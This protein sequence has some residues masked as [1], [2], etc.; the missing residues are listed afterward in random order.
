MNFPAGLLGDGWANGA[1]VLL[2]IILVWCLRTAPWRR[3]ADSGQWNVWLGSIVILTL[4]WSMNAGI[5]PGLNMHLLGVTAFTLMFDRQLAIV[6]L[7]VVLAVVTYNSG[8]LGHPLG[9]HSF[10]LNALLMV[11]FPAFLARGILWLV[12]R[13]LPA[14]FFVYL[15]VGTFFSAA[16]NTVTTG[17]LATGILAVAGVYS[18]DMLYGD[19]FLS[20]ILLGFAEAWLNGAAV[21]LMVVY[22]PHWVGTFDD[23]RYLANK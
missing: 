20:Y 21:T 7:C 9:W 14:N 11:V 17:L 3:L 23:A 8:V 5:R 19:Y 18:T 1:F 15:F 22:Y 2:A 12:E 10:A 6:G 13:Y 16:V 4:M